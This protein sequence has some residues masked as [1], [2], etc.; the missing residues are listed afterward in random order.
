MLDYIIWLKSGECITGIAKKE[1]VE[2][3]QNLF[4]NTKEINEKILFK[5]LDG[6]AAIDLSRVEAIAANMQL[7][8]N[9]LGF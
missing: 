5:D 4:V 9:K 7:E 3:L 1:V 2:E 8:T 6:V